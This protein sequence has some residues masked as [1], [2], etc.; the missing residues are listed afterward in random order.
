MRH[1]DLAVSFLHTLKFFFWKIVTALSSLSSPTWHPGPSPRP[2]RVP[3]TQHIQRGPKTHSKAEGQCGVQT[4]P[5][6][7]ACSV[8]GAAP[9]EGR[10]G[11]FPWPCTPVETSH[12]LRETCCR[13]AIKLSVK[14]RESYLIPGCFPLHLYGCWKEVIS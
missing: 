7:A 8:F 5:G 9:G 4:E 1:I 11:C 13:L 3:M 6:L 2:S 12:I 14:E 10:G